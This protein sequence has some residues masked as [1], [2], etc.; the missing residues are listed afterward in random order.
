SAS[1]RL[2]G[3]L[4]LVDESVVRPDSVRNQPWPELPFASFGDF[5]SLVQDSNLTLLLSTSTK[6]Q[7]QR[8]LWSA[9]A[10]VLPTLSLSAG[11]NYSASEP[12]GGIGGPS[13]KNNSSSTLSVG[14][15]LPILDLPSHLLNVRTAELQLQQAQVSH[16]QALIGLH[17]AAMNTW[18]A[19]ERAR[20]QLDYAI[21]NLKLS[22]DLYRLAQEQYR[23]GQLTTLD[24]FSVETALTQAEV[25]YL[26]ALCDIQKGQA[27][28]D[29]LLG[30]WPSLQ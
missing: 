11:H 9:R 14:L 2:K 25:G 29:Y 4:G 17:Q 5:W 3:L 13:W 12:P 19:Y 27:Q 10:R 1:E 8:T 16:R 15:S 7:A 30:R 26:N 21:S 22:N 6:L 18:L 28:I 23:L 24:L 20:S